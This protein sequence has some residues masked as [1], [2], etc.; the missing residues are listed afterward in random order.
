[1]RQRDGDGKDVQEARVI[2][3]RDENVVTDARNVTGRWR[4]Y[5]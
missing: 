1:M 2:K 5:F 3:D 4:E